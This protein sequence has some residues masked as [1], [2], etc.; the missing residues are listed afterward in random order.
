MG[1]QV[2]NNTVI[3]PNEKKPQQPLVSDFKFKPEDFRGCHPGIVDANKAAEIANKKLEEWL[4]ESITLYA[5]NT[6]EKA[7]AWAIE[8]SLLLEQHEAKFKGKIVC[9]EPI[10]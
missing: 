6:P 1:Y 8:G 2:E 10:G 3:M 9:I 4:S 5:V 7:K